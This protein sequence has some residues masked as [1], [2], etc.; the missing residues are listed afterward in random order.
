M[1]SLFFENIFL[2]INKLVVFYVTA[3]GIPFSVIVSL[4]TSL[5]KAESLLIWGPDN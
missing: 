2:T 4:E 1:S 5:D 3:T